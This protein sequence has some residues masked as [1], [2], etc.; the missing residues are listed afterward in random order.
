MYLDARF[1][2]GGNLP[3]SNIAREG[4]EVMAVGRKSPARIHA[5]KGCQ[6]GHLPLRRVERP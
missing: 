6:L 3:R 1:W 5:L 2:V 4:G